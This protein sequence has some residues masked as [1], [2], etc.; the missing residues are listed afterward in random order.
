MKTQPGHKT[1]QILAGI[2]GKQVK[3]YI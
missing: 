3:L 1:N 2:L